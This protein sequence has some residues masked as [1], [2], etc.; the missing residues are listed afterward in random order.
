MMTTLLTVESKKPSGTHWPTSS[1]N[2]LTLKA[3]TMTSRV[4]KKR[5]TIDVVEDIDKI[6]DKIEEETGV[7]MTYVQTFD[8]LIHFYMR[9]C[10][11]PKTRWVGMQ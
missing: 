4:R 9:H 11:E 10:N 3:K 7:C 5:I 8:F 6:R 2:G 1:M